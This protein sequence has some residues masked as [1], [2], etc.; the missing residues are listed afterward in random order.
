MRRL[1]SQQPD[2]ARL[3]FMCFPCPFCSFS[4]HKKRLTDESGIHGVYLCECRGAVGDGKAKAIVC[5]PSTCGEVRE[6]HFL[7]VDPELLAL[8]FAST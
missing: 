3:S 4:G 7:P 2:R 8:L 1:G 5:S 6:L